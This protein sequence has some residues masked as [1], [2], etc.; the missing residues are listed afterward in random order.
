MK[1][2][3]L[4]GNFPIK[5]FGATE[6]FELRRAK[7]QQAEQDR[8]RMQAT[9]TAPP[10]YRIAVGGLLGEDADN[11]ATVVAGQFITEGLLSDKKKC[12]QR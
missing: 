1:K 3:R 6:V 9:G 7:K 10:V 2:L 11:A 4:I 12:R 8:E 5:R